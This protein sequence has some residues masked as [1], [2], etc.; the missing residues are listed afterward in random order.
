LPGHQKVL[1][2]TIPLRQKPIRFSGWEDHCLYRHLP[3]ECGSLLLL[4]Q[5][6]QFAD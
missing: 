5:L 2:T 6:Q 1:A 4:H 3:T